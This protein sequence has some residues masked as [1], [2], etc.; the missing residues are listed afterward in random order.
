MNPYRWR[1]TILRAFEEGVRP[2]AVGLFAKLLV[3]LVPVAGP[4]LEL[5]ALAGGTASLVVILRRLIDDLFDPTDPNRLLVEEISLAVLL[6][7]FLRRLLGWLGVML[8]LCLV[9]TRL[10]LPRGA[11]E[12]AWLLLKIGVAWLVL[13]RLMQKRRILRLVRPRRGS[14]HRLL[15]HFLSRSYLFFL[16]VILVDLTFWGL[17]F[18]RL[19]GD[20][21]RSGSL[22]MACLVVTAMLWSRVDH[23]LPRRTHRDGERTGEEGSGKSLV[24]WSSEDLIRISFKG[25]LLGLLAASFFF[26]W[27]GTRSGL[28]PLFLVFRSTIEVGGFKVSLA[29][30]LQAVV[31]V[32]LLVALSHGVRR[33]L[34]TRIYP[35]TPLDRGIRLA[36]NS[37]L[38]YLLMGVAA[39]FVIEAFGIGT[40]SI[41]WFAGFIGIGVGFGMQAIVNN[42]ASGIIILV[43]RPIKPGDQISV[44]GNEGE[45]TK[46]SV[47]ATTIRSRDNIETIV[48]NSEFIGNAVTNWSYTD[49]TVRLHVPVGVAYGSD[50][51]LVRDGLLK[52]A[53]KHRLVLKRPAPEVWFQSFGE[54]S[55]D[56]ELLVWTRHPFRGPRIRSDL[57]YAIDAEFR[58]R[59]IEIPFPQRDLHI[60]GGELQVRSGSILEEEAEEEAAAAPNLP[61]GRRKS[62]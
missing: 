34:D 28:E 26:L 40:D 27:G 49:P 24:T 29:R 32:S 45:V 59:G 2:L 52:V 6:H 38:H 1:A 25:F 10:G 51:K 16:L 56:F 13:R 31:S 4:Q 30:L 3:L 17:G 37:F 54:S 62:S 43:E 48:P 42:L 47:R 46:I 33:F 5:A 36:I 44:G 60:R 20:L 61:D 8:P 18:H 58:R 7:D 39:L 15:H 21:A 35:S 57:N 50:V 11:N 23:R 12:L 41:K 19:A 14:G 9:T 53:T 55:L 22:S